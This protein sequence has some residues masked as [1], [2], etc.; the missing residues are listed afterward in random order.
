MNRKLMALNI[1]LGAAIVYGGVEL[2]GQWQAAKARQDRIAAGRVAPAPPPPFTKLPEVEPVMA[3]GY[4]S[5]A[6]KF[7]LDPSRN[8]DLPIP[9]PE[10]VVV[11][12]PPVMPPLPF[13]HAMMNIGNGPEIVM[14]EKS[15][16]QHK[17]IH[18][19]E[20]IGEFKLV[21]FNSE[22]IELEWNGQRMVKSVTELSGHGA[23]PNAEPQA[24]P[25][26]ATAAPA[27]TVRE[28]PTPAALGP[29]EG[30]AAG[31]RACQ[32]GDTMPVGTEIDGVVKTVGKHGL[33]G[34][35][36]CIWKPK[37]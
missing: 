29:G 2:H 30:N 12:P 25:A 6:Q 32:P 21:A 7:L 16:S 28:A 17:R 15:G 22:Q 18:P 33:F 24:A 20:S 10:K 4:A 26:E 9:E 27:P 11:P 5:V 37:R 36:F 3:S 1:A 31:E 35:E 19:G 23:G 13:F 34:G 14:S 8:S